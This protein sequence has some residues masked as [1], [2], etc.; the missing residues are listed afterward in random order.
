MI[1]KQDR[2]WLIDYEYSQVNFR[3]ND[4]AN[5]IAETQFAY[6]EPPAAYV[7]HPENKWDLNGQKFKEMVNTYLNKE[8][9]EEEFT[10]FRDEV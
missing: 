3:A 4:V 2:L 6:D 5:F 8:A 7:Y 10:Q 9:S 1:D